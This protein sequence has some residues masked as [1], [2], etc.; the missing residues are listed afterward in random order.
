[1]E[2]VLYC[3]MSPT[4][5][6]VDCN[7]IVIRSPLPIYGNDNTNTTLAQAVY[8]LTVEADENT[9]QVSEIIHYVYCEAE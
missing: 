8:A 4:R 5:R 6:V 3:H 9:E 2:A 7:H 1:M